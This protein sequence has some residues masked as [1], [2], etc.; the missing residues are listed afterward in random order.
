MK[1]SED[2]LESACARLADYLESHKHE[3]I[4]DWVAQA[5]TDS[6]VPSCALTKLEIV[7]HVPNIFDAMI[8]AL[9]KQCSETAMEKVQEVAARH[10]VVRWVQS[11]DLQAVIR[12][13]A[14]LRTEFIRHLRN[15]DDQ[16]PHFG[17]DA[18]LFNST[19]IHRILDD[20]VMDAT[21]TFLKLRDRDNG[22][23]A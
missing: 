17:S 9:R 10:T 7:D 14:L 18:R 3:L 11:Y 6:D 21:E 13:V 15:F 20:I 1:N 12:E 19:T 23:E 5:R 8:Q 2:H 4:D 22:G 16:H